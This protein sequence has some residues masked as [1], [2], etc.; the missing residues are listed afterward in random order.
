MS[1]NT[2]ISDELRATLPVSLHKFVDEI[3]IILTEV[4]NKN[5]TGGLASVTQQSNLGINAILEELKGSQFPV[6]NSVISF[7]DNSNIG[8]VTI[9]DVANNII[10][11]KF[12]L[13]LQPEQ[14]ETVQE[15]VKGIPKRLRDLNEIE[16]IFQYL[17]T[18][19]YNFAM[20]MQSSPEKLNEVLIEI[21]QSPVH[22]QDKP[23]IRA[24]I[25]EWLDNF[26]QEWRVFNA[27]LKTFRREFD[28]WSHQMERMFQ[29]MFNPP[30]TDN[31]IPKY[32]V[33]E[34][35][36]K[37]SNLVSNLNQLCSIID[38]VIKVINSDFLSRDFLSA[39]R[40]D[41]LSKTR[42]EST[43]ELLQLKA[44]FVRTA[45][46]Y[47]RIQITLTVLIKTL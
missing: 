12:N 46:F 31:T 11:V 30:N 20:H 39:V 45:E 15:E 23:R 25:Q 40:S 32:Q 33:R 5:K 27:A 28:E 2:I 17:N 47:S 38:K 3:S 18:E 34:M 7:G 35:L 24:M 26:V 6:R 19:M 42:N 10:K 36:N 41:K 4:I 16:A 14:A 29:F 13:F 8:D 44:S 37:T 22:L 1:S 9:R 21:Q 43:Q